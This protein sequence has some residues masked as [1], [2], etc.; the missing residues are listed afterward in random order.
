MP[1]LGGL[2]ALLLAVGLGR[3]LTAGG[4]VAS[5]SAATTRPAKPAAAAP[6][7]PDP[8]PGAGD[9]VARRP[10]RV[11]VRLDAA[12]GKTWV[13]VT[14]SD[15]KTLYEGTLDKGARKTFTDRSRVR[16]V[17][18]NSGAVDL[19]VNGKDLGAPGKGR[20]VARAELDTSDYVV[21]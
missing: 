13:S 20:P 11:T 7:A 4:D 3:V 1:A 21:G 8:G 16:L 9:P 19:V 5:Q 10:D 17:V 12:R 2:L 6:P 14:N 15:G 18:G